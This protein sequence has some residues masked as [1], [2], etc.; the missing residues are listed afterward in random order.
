VRRELKLYQKPASPAWW[1]SDATYFKFM[2]RELSAVFVVL[3]VVLSILMLRAI[4]AGED[5]YDAFLS[6]LTNPGMIA[7]HVVALAFVLL[8]TTTWFSLAPKAL[9]VFRGAERVPDVAIVV[10]HWIGMV[11]VSLVVGYFLVRG[12]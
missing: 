9:P 3:G 2:M 10:P 1:L 7:L 5:A 11:V 12:I 6:M 4:A 8:H